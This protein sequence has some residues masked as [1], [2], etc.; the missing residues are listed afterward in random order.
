MTSFTHPQKTQAFV[1]FIS[2]IE[3]SGLLF[4]KKKKKKWKNSIWQKWKL[5]LPTRDMNSSFDIW[6]A[7]KSKRLNGGRRWRTTTEM[8]LLLKA[9]VAIIRSLFLKKIYVHGLTSFWIGW[10]S[11]LPDC[12]ILAWW[13]WVW[14]WWWWEGGTCPWCAWGAWPWCAGGRWPWWDGAACPWCALWELS[15]KAGC[16]PVTKWAI[17]S[18]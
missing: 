3:R 17:L 14:W 4:M 12:L 1:V 6:K 9:F 18:F 5:S 16:I 7:L 13:C 2:V 15:T 10:S 11:M 8:L